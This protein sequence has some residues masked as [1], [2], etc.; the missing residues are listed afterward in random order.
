MGLVGATPFLIAAAATDVNLM[1]VLL[2]GG[3]DPLLATKDKTTPLIVAAGVGWAED[4]PAG[5]D[6]NA[7]EAVRL[8]LEMGADANT[9][10]A[11][12]HTALHG[13][14]YTGNNPVVQFLAD[15]GTN[16][17][18]KDMNGQTPLDVAEGLAPKGSYSVTPPPVH[19]E[20][21]DLL[22]KLG[23]SSGLVPISQ[24]E[25]MGPD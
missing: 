23:A 19:K 9:A 21:A 22:R 16:L 25:V 13:A 14:A 18:A 3:A 17:N 24:T 8:I 2:A 10:N 4:R 12:G 7:L 15:K 6:K 11:S 1:R 5:Q 20:T